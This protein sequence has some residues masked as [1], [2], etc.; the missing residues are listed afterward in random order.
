MLCFN[1]EMNKHKLRHSVNTYKLSFLFFKVCTVCLVIFSLGFII[2]EQNQMPVKDAKLYDWNPKSFWYY[3]WG[4]SRVHKG[5]DIFAKKGTDILAPTVGL[6]L[7]SGQ[8]RLGGNVV[9]M[10]G[11]KWRL[12][13]FAHL[14]TL[15]VND[16]T[17]VGAGEKIGT[18]GD[19]GNAKGKQPHLHYSIRS[20]FPQVWEYQSE[21]IAA[22]SRMFYVDPDKFLRS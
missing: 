7:F 19:S 20:L 18:V 11:A 17:L 13:Y 1:K 8:N 6:V 5:I 4:R 9:L 3:P 21:T 15:D 14:E 2:P 22:W 12:H 16:L 10:I